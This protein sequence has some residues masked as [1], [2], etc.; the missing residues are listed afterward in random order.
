M[1][2]LR[3]VEKIAGIKFVP[4]SPPKPEDI[5]KAASKDVVKYVLFFFV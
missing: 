4:I 2:A 5:L 3:Q 1:F